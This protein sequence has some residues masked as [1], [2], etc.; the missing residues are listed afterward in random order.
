MHISKIIRLEIILLILVHTRGTLVSLC[1]FL[2]IRVED[3]SNLGG[4]WKIRDS[5]S[6][7]STFKKEIK[8]KDV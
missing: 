8:R 4:G 2:D 1:T 5:V 6:H 3:V 7:G